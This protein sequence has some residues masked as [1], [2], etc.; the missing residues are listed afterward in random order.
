MQAPEPRYSVQVL[1]DSAQILGVFGPQ[2]RPLGIAE[3]SRTIGIGRS[4]V[5]RL[6]D[7]LRFLGFVEHDEVTRQYRLGLRIFELA[8]AASS[9]FD[10]G[11]AAKQ[12]LQHLV[13][14]T[15][16]TVNV[17]VLLQ[18]NEILYVDNLRGFGPLRLEVEL[19]TRAPANCVALGKAILAFDS[20]ERLEAVL[21]RP[22]LALTRNSISDPQRFREELQRVRETGYALDDEE[23]FPGVRCVAVPIV[24]YTGLPVAAIAVSGP[25]ARLPL[26]KLIAFAQ[27]LKKTAESISVS[28]V[29]SAT[30]SGA[31]ADRESLVDQTDELGNVD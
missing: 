24:D 29:V 16:E 28:R 3:I 13:E 6:L 26:S 4:K 12:A 18:G 31:G 20:P 14:A 9:H 21:A 27:P 25:A 15:G 1:I 5:H 10:L 22:L 17:G 23:S 11:P 30:S 19:G 7:T 8:A 2:N